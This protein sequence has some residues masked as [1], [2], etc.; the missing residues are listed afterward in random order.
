[1]PICEPCIKGDGSECHTPGCALWL[2]RVDL[3]MHPE[4]AVDVDA[5]G[6]RVAELEALIDTPHTTEFFEAVRMEAA[7]QVK[8]WGV[9]RDAGKEPHDWFWLLGFLAG[10]A[11]SKPE[12]RRH[13]I[14]SSAAALLN[15]FRAETGDSDAMRPGIEPPDGAA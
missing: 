3:P 15:W 2:H 8:R 13:H 6:A 5:L 12:K 10:K 11:L 14:I 1:M 7:H 4:L 9:D